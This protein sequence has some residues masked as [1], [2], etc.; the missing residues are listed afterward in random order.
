MNWLAVSFTLASLWFLGGRTTHARMIGF[1]LNMLGAVAWILWA[2][3]E[4]PDPG[5]L[6]IVNA[7]ILA[8]AVVG[9]WR[10]ERAP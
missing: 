9:V 2:L 4:V 1:L 10:L 6:L 5:A 3:F 7:A 8:F